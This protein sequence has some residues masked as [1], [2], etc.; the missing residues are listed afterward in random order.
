MKRW[1]AIAVA[2][3]AF[4]AFAYL[5][6]LTIYFAVRDLY[7]RTIAEEGFVRVGAHR[8]HYY[9]LGDGPPLLLVHGVASRAADAA[10]LFRSLARTHRVYAPDLLGY[11]HSDQPRDSDYSVATQ[12]EILRGFMD[13]MRLQQTDVLGMSMGGWITLKIAAEHPERVKRLVL[14][15][16]AGVDFPSTLDERG[17]SPETMDELRA[18]FARQSDRAA[19][20]ASIHEFLR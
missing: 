9:A 19:A 2:L 15:S 17:F 12:A 1:T 5:R 20:L 7:L 3:L 18:S 8:I 4:V 6:P 16:S 10:P 11:G 14:V 13:A